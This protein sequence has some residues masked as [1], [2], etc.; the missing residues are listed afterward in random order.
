MGEELTKE[1]N[2][3][4]VRGR[5]GEKMLKAFQNAAATIEIDLLK[6]RFVNFQR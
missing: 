5:I 2:F 1:K 3:T 6:R 4:G